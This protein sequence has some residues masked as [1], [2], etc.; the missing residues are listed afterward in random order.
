MDRSM[1]RINILCHDWLALK[2]VELT[3]T[4]VSISDSNKNTKCRDKTHPRN[5]LRI[6]ILMY[7]R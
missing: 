1:H 2:T 4:L 3:N 7:L 6:D 5:P